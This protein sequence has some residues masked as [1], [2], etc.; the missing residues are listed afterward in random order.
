[1]RLLLLLAALLLT[2]CARDVPEQ[3]TE[4]TYATP[5]PPS[6][7]FSRADQRW[8]DFVEEESQGRL[9][10]RP[11]WS[12]ALLSAD[13]SMEELRHGVADIGLITP[14]YVRGGT[15]LLRI[16]TGFYSGADSVESQV[17]LYRCL[18]ARIPQISRELDG[19]KVLAVQGGLLPGILTRGKR[20]EQLSDLRGLRIRAPTELLAV[21]Q[22][23]GADPVNMPMGEVYSALAKGVI[24]GVI[25]P[26]DTLRAL[27][28]AEVTDY[29]YDLR[30]PRGAYPARAMGLERWRQLEPWQRDLLERSVAAW[31]E[32]LADEIR[33]SE[34]VGRAAGE[35]RIIYS[36]AT[37]AEQR[38]FDQIYLRDAEENARALEQFGID[39]LEAFKLARASFAARDRISCGDIS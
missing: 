11:I 34:A 22:N 4:L 7:P 14:I 3:V 39:G 27:H 17:A 9:V 2:A 13:M 12:G 33:K 38:H 35:G 37:P 24:D 10:I 1:M 29:F 20:V 28:L 32:A 6:H 5:Y 31:E 8:I 30:V 25:A 16:Q 36:S 19:L 15:H 21:L 18:E 23:L 26:L